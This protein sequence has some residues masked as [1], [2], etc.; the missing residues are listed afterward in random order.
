MSED[1]KVQRVEI[2]VSYPLTDAMVEHR[3]MRIAELIKTKSEMEAARTAAAKAAQKD[4][5]KVGEEI[6][7]LGAEIRTKSFLTKVEA[8]KRPCFDT[9]TWQTVRIDTE[10]YGLVVSEEPMTA[11]ERQTAID[12]DRGQPKPAEPPKQ[13]RVG[14]R[15][16]KSDSPAPQPPVGEQPTH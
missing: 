14:R 10:G 9:N 2:Q 13:V 11:A 8:E 15:K 4:I 3:G 7:K 6:D 1:L 5:D 12:V 16:P